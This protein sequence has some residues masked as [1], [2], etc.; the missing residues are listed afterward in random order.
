MVSGDGNGLSHFLLFVS[1]VCQSESQ[2]LPGNNFTTECNIPGNFMCGDG[3]CVPVKWQ[4]DGLP[5]CFDK[6]DEKG[7]RKFTFFFSLSIMKSR[8]R[9]TSAFSKQLNK[10]TY[11]NSVCCTVLQPCF[12]SLPRPKS[13]IVQLNLIVCQLKLTSFLNPQI[14]LPQVHAPFHP[15][16][17]PSPLAQ[18]ST[19]TE[20]NTI[21]AKVDYFCVQE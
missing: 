11:L 18:F 3:K 8:G 4:C 2:L 12:C 15:F 1:R 6:S 13:H 5:D 20:F 17:S 14:T 7:C 10:I 19:R 16:F 21:K 9:P